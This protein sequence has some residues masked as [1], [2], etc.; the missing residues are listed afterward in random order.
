V[1]F[2]RSVARQAVG[3]GILLVL[4]AL[5]AAWWR[6]WREQWQYGSVSAGIVLAGERWERRRRFT[7]S[8]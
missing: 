4:W 7:P 2:E 5:D 3:A 6:R 8:G 1:T